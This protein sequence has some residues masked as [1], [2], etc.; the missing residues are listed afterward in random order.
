MILKIKSN[1]VISI[2]YLNKSKPN[3]DI[4]LEELA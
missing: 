2:K 3:M 4:E 1:I